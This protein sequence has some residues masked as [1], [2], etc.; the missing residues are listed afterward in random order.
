[1]EMKDKGVWDVRIT[2][3]DIF[4]ALVSL[5][6]VFIFFILSYQLINEAFVNPQV[7]EDIESYIAVLGILSGPA[8]MAISRF[9]DRW[10]A[11]QEERVE[12]LRRM[13]KTDDDLKRMK[14]KGEKK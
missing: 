14:L 8:Y 13:S 11:E 9:F 2:L 4:V 10:N 3:N 6:M 12:G 7:R 5:P 1:M